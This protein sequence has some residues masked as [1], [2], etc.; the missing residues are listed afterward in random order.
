MGELGIKHLVQIAQEIRRF[1]AEEEANGEGQ[2]KRGHT[3]RNEKKN[4]PSGV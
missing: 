2:V 3:S 4:I 1:T